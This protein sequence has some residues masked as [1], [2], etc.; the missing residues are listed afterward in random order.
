MA[1]DHVERRNGEIR[2]LVKD[3]VGR[4]LEFIVPSVKGGRAAKVTEWRN[5]AAQQMK[6]MGA[7]PDRAAQVAA[8]MEERE[9]RALADAPTGP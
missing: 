8:R 6:D 1:L 7:D 4:T 3:Q 9:M 2:R 5:R